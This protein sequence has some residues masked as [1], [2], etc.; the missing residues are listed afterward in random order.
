M[1]MYLFIILL[2]FNLLLGLQ[3]MLSALV[4]LIDD[5]LRVEKNTCHGK[6]QASQKRNKNLKTECIL[7]RKNS[8]QIQLVT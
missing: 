5:M 7:T 3:I 1:Y 6:F 2:Y 8:K 4:H